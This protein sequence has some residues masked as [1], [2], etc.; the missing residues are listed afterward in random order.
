MEKQ[1]KDPIHPEG[2]EEQA[3]ALKKEADRLKEL[4]E[5]NQDDTSAQPH[6]ID[7][8]KKEDEPSTLLPF[9]GE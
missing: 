2:P 3:E 5:A 6:E 1:T 4:E 7:T 9:G 8:H